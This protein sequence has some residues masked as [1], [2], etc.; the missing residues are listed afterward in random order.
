MTTSLFHYGL[1]ESGELCYIIPDYTVLESWLGQ[2]LIPHKLREITITILTPGVGISTSGVIDSQEL[3]LALIHIFSQYDTW[4]SQQSI[5]AQASVM[6]VSPD[7]LLNTIIDTVV[8]EADGNN[9]PLA[10]VFRDQAR[11]DYTNYLAQMLQ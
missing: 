5:E 7:Q 1:L 4:C 8:C 11:R 9:S 10:Q 6:M 3:A 2:V